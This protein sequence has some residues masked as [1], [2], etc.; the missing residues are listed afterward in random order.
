[1]TSDD[2]P[3]MRPRPPYHRILAGSGEAIF[4]SLPQ[5]VLD[6]LRRPNSENALVWNLV[7]PV[8]TPTIDHASL[9][10]VPPLW[11]TAAAHPEHDD[12]T[13][14]YWGYAVSGE[15][16]SALSAALRDA[17][18]AGPQTEVDLILAGQK[19]LVLVEAKH[20]SGLGRCSRYAK[21]SCPEIHSGDEERRD[22]CRYWHEPLSRF[23]ADL[24]LGERPKPGTDS[25]PCNRHYQLARTLR[26]G[27]LLS[28]RMGLNLS[29]WLIVPRPHWHTL[30]RTWLDFTER[31]RED[32]SWRRMRVL[33][34]EDVAA[35]PRSTGH[36]G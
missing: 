17:D 25:P 36:R 27:A 22:P 14:Y 21:R 29:L 32:E 5:R 2:H 30:E 35:L 15:K 7:Y 6:N 28:R 23:A 11:G 13:P 1:M 12:L 16:L 34:W 20:M 9:L 24:D 4:K 8:A 33:A 26:V 18:G 10:S 19:Q 31:V 3:V